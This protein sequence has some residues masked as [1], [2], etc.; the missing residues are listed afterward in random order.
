MHDAAPA[1][2]WRWLRSPR[3]L[4]LA[5]L[6]GAGV[7]YLVT[8]HG[9][10]TLELLPYGLVVLCLGLHLFM[11]RN[12]GGHG[13]HGGNGGNGAP[14]DHAHPQRPDA[15]AEQEHRHG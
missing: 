6:L 3:G 8:A 7:Y 1:H 13:G 9:S 4:A 2:P 11:H 12:H 15:T 5:A 14:A 10:H